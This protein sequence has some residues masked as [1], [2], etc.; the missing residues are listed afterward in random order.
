MPIAMPMSD[1]LSA[2]ASLTPSPVIAD[3]VA[4]ALEDVDQPDLLLGRHAGDHADLV[5]L[6]VGL[7]LAE[8]RELARRRSRGPDAELTRDRLGG[9]GVVAGDHP[10]LDAGG[11][12]FGDRRLGR[13]TRRVDDARPARAS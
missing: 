2:G 7:V 6:L 9:D 13:R 11:V 10:H 3:D 4:L 8:L 5:D 1:C 12:R